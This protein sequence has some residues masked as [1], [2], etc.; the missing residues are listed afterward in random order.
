M[1]NKIPEG[2]VKS[3]SSSL[4]ILKPMRCDVCKRLAFHLTRWEKDYPNNPDL[5]ICS[6]CELENEYEE[7]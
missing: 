5:R 3:Y 6:T 1:A 7:I 2:Y 4:S